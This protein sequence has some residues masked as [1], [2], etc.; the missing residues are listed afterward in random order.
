[1]WGDSSVLLPAPA[2]APG[3]R[4]SKLIIYFNHLHTHKKPK[5]ISLPEFGC[6]TACEPWRSHSPPD[7]HGGSIFYPQPAPQGSQQKSGS[8]L[9]HLPPLPP[10][11]DTRSIVSLLT[12]PPL[13]FSRFL[14]TLQGIYISLPY[15][16]KDLTSSLIPSQGTVARGIF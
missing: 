3:Q 10:P 16:C 12:L 15:H 4:A 1:M 9:W 8:N 14:P 6:I 2:Q 7:P 11:P 13:P 5:Y